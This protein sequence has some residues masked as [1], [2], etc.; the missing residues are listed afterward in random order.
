MIATLLN[1]AL[2]AVPL[3]AVETL[4]YGLFGPVA[5]ARPA[6]ASRRSVLLF[7]DLAGPDGATAAYARGLAERGGLVFTVS[8]PAYL[9]RLEALNEKC[10]YP[11]G[12]VEELAHWMERHVAM[13][14]YQPPYLAGFGAGAGFVYALGVQAPAGT[15]AGVATLGWDFDLRLPRAFCPGDAGVATI[16]AARGFRIAPVTP[17]PLPWAAPAPAAGAR[18]NGP[19]GALRELFAYVPDAQAHDGAALAGTLDALNAPPPGA[20]ANDDALGDLPLT[21]IAPQGAEDGRIAVILTGDGGWAGLDKGVAAVLAQ[22]GVRVVGMSSLEFFWHKRTPEE[23]A[24]AVARIVRHYGTQYPHAR[25]VLIGYSF[26]A[27]L[28]PVVANRLPEDAR[29]R[30]AGGVMISPDPEAVFEI[31]VGDWFGDVHQPG[32]LPV[33]PEVAASKVPLVCVSGQ[34]EQGAYCT[35]PAARKQVHWVQL[36]GGHH[37]EGDYAKLGQAILEALPE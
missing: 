22:H 1:L 25:F 16:A 35:G 4:D 3:P 2:A 28:V 8:L 21:E 11:A 30:V 5:I 12:H 9:K 33:D 26:G 32:A 19:F 24:Q 34:T 13:P 10:S 31:K 37:Y 27:G 18:M 14:G 17:L 15:F 36:P 29:S 23:T 6:G 20:A 7:S